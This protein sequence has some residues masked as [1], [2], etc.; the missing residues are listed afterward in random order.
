M[1]VAE[2]QN[3]LLN[4]VGAKQTLPLQV[5][6]LGGAGRGALQEADRPT[7]ERQLDVVSDEVGAFRDLNELRILIPCTK[8][9]H[10]PPLNLVLS[11]SSLVLGILVDPARV[12][13]SPSSSQKCVLVD[14]KVRRHVAFVLRL[15]LS[16]ISTKDGV[17][18]ESLLVLFKPP[19]C[20]HE[21][22]AVG[23][24]VCR[25]ASLH[26]VSHVHVQLVKVG[27]QVLVLLLLG[28]IH[29]Q[30][31]NSRLPLR[32]ALLQVLLARSRDLM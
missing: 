28:E 2:V 32:E 10:E 22:D 5:D 14:K 20:F 6:T 15:S 30:V 1:H 18:P 29:E 31:Q 24:D 17:L 4:I 13:D 3:V 11:L 25:L 26:D 9:A 23:E 12:L 8:L 21:S 27:S 7:K 16:P 19:Q